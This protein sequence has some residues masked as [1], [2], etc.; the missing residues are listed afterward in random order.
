MADCSAC[1]WASVP[2]HDLNRCRRCTTCHGSGAPLRGLGMDG[3]HEA[4]VGGV[5]LV[6][7]HQ[8][9]PRLLVQRRL[10]ERLYQQAPASDQAA[11]MANVPSTPPPLSSSLIPP[12]GP[13]GR[14]LCSNRNSLRPPVVPRTT[15]SSPLSLRGWS[16][17]CSQSA[18]P[19]AT[20]GAAPELRCQ[21][22]G[23][24]RLNTAAVTCNCA[25]ACHSTQM[26]PVYPHTSTTSTA[27]FSKPEPRTN[28]LCRDLAGA[29]DARARA[30]VTQC[31]Q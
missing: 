26:M 6:V 5:R 10:R 14:S 3:G 30:D 31:P 23:V 12:Q 16:Q 29:R 13:Q 22:A 17:R 28:Y 20:G 24:T 2:R 11:T 4:G 15:I 19:R 7:L 18:V 21:D 8:Q 25:F 9:P 27:G 1:A